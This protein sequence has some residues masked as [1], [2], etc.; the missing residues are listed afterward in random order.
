[1][2]DSSGPSLSAD[3]LEEIAECQGEIHKDYYARLAAMRARAPI[4]NVMAIFSGTRPEPLE[5]RRPVKLKRIL[6]SYA[7]ALFDCE[8]ARYPQP[9]QQHWLT[10][11]AGRVESDVMRAVDEINEHGGFWTL[12]HHASLEAMHRAIQDGLGPRGVIHHAA[13]KQPKH[14]EER[15]E[16]RTPMEI[17][18]SYCDRESISLEELAD[19]AGIDRGC[20][21]QKWTIREFP[22]LVA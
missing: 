11:L 18:D 16:I 17:I 14:S 2:D 9:I 15:P 12:W 6:A 10:N 13:E 5:P 1:M 19:K 4:R 3:A 21:T 8:V 22:F 20:A 7:N